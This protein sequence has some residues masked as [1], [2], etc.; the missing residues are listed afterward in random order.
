MTVSFCLDTSIW[1]KYFCPDEQ[2]EAATNLVVNALN[3]RLV[4]PCFAWA[5][6]A[7]V[8]RK[9]VRANLLT[10]NE[11]GQ[12]YRAFCDFPID[13]LDGDEIR[14]RAWEIAEQYQ[15]LTLYD[16]V[17]LAVAEKG[18]AQYWTADLALLKALVPQP[19]YV[20]ALADVSA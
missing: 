15:L 9:K 1:I 14:S 13:Y 12:I 16:S 19:N 10:S 17:F 6:I 3:N 11:S 5:E 4:S 2:E 8:L 18:S 20:Y 7:S